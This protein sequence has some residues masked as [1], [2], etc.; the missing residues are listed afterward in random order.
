MV[1][2]CVR[3]LASGRFAVYK[4]DIRVCTISCSKGF[5]SQVLR[6][7]FLFVPRHTLLTASAAE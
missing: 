6:K 4:S 2:L 3:I 1:F 7:S 5:P